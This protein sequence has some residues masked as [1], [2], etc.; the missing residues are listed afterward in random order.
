MVAVW[1]GMVRAC[2]Q[3]AL[4]PVLSGMVKRGVGL[5]T[6]VRA[7]MRAASLAADAQKA[8]VL[9]HQISQDKAGAGCVA[10]LAG[11]AQPT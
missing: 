7:C 1:Y 3:E 2:V 5:N 6:K 11:A 8:A 9:E 10:P 4:V